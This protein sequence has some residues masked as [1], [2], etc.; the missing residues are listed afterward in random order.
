MNVEATVSNPDNFT[1][2]VPAFSGPDQEE[3]MSR[4]EVQPRS[5]LN[6]PLQF[7]PTMLGAA[8][9]QATSK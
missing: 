7:M 4:F 9:H 8:N 2:D 5:T 1:L 6:V 3:S